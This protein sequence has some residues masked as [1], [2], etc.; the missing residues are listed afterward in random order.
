MP[1]ALWHGQSGLTALAGWAP[2]WHWV[3]PVAPSTHLH[4]VQVALRVPS[5]AQPAQRLLLTPSSS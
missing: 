1:L 4:Q 3:P 2:G 5:Q